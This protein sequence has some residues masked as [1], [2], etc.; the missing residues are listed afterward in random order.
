[1]TRRLLLLLVLSLGACGTT[2]GGLSYDATQSAAPDPAGAPVISRVVATDARGESDPHWLGTIRGGFGNPLRSVTTD[3]PVADEVAQ[4]FRQALASRGLLAP[5]GAGRYNMDVTVVRMDCDQYH[6]REANADFRVVLTD[7]RSGRQI[8]Q[9][10]VSSH[11][12][13][14]SIVTFSTGIFADPQD[15]RAIAAQAQNQ[16]IDTAL[17]KPAFLAALRGR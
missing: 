4:G 1:M 17:G 13:N 8:Y 2:T 5:P 9:D 3:A 7:R 12:V 6:R 10:E 11:L 14:G 16:A 15:L